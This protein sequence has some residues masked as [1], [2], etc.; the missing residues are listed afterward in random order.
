[1]VVWNWPTRSPK[2][3]LYHKCKAF[4]PPRLTL[5]NVWWSEIWHSVIGVNAKCPLAHEPLQFVK[6]AMAAQVF[7]TNPYAWF[8]S[9][10]SLFFNEGCLW[11]H[12]VPLDDPR[13]STHPK[14]LNV[15]TSAQF[16]LSPNVRYSQ[17]PVIRVW[18]FGVGVRNENHSASHTGSV[19]PF[20]QTS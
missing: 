11:L 14:T 4:K 3:C 2:V 10:V 20:Y 7:S 18:T 19:L 17:I 15:I 1:M 5:L 12:W 8:D 6:A 13:S 16:I 9:L